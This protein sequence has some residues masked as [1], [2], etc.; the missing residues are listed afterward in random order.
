M[1]DTAAARARRRHDRREGR[2][3][4]RAAQAAGVGDA[5]HPDRSIRTRG[6][7]S[8][9]GTTCW[10]RRS[11]PSPRCCREAPGEVVACG[12]DHQ[13]E[14]VIAW[15]AETGAPLSPN[16]VWQDKR[17]MDLLARLADAGLEEEIKARS[18]LPLDPVLLRGQARRGCSTP[19]TRCRPRA[20]AARCGWARSTRSCATGSA[21]ASRPTP[22]PRRACSCSPS[23]RR[24]GT[25]GCARRSA[26]RADALPRIE[27]TVGEL[28]TLRDPS[29]GTGSCR[30][31]R[32]SWTS[33]RRWRAPDASCPGW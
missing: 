6:G 17:A 32:G 26:C 15:D 27:D 30:C 10:R 2:A 29:A 22:R 1:S 13:G 12:L 24:T 9:P 25:R 20:S 18:G 11:S 4:R 14:S 23:A 8:R 19:A 16:L 31:A 33:R 7:W 5:P 3:G 21:R 28:G